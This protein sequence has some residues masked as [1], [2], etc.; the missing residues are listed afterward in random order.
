MIEIC[1]FTYY[2]IGDTF[3]TGFDG[4]VCDGDRFGGFV[5]PDTCRFGTGGGG[6]IAVE[7]VVFE[8]DLVRLVDRESFAIKEYEVVLDK[9]F[10]VVVARF[11]SLFARIILLLNQEAI[12][13]IDHHTGKSFC[14]D[15]GDDTALIA[16]EE[17]AHDLDLG[18]GKVVDL[19]DIFD[20]QSPCA[21]RSPPGVV[22]DDIVADGDIVTLACD[23]EPTGRE[24][25][26]GRILH[27]NMM[28]LEVEPRLS[29]GFGRVPPLVDHFLVV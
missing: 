2:T 13:L 21:T 17:V 27:D 18:F 4:I 14:K 12:P 19:M 16:E 23:L 1:R 11:G 3:A 15:M 8:D 29:Q 25:P 9:V 20:Y 6:A 5:D 24:V 26:K 22:V 7:G 10:A 28:T